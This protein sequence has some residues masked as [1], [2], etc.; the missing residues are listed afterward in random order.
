MIECDLKVFER[1]K[2]VSFSHRQ[3]G[4][5][6]ETLNCA[7]RELAFCCEPIEDEIL[8]PTEHLR[9]V[10]HGFDARTH[11]PSAPGVKKIL[12]DLDIGECPE[13]LEVFPKKIGP[14]RRQIQFEKLGETDRLFL[15]EVLWALENSPA[16]IFQ[17]ILL[18]GR[19]EFGNLHAPNLI[20]GLS[21]LLHDVKAI[22]NIQCLRGFL[23]DDFQVGWGQ[24]ITAP[25]PPRNPADEL[26]RTGLGPLR[27]PGFLQSRLLSTNALFPENS[28]EKSV[29]FLPGLCRCLACGKVVVPLGMKGVGLSSDLDMPPD[30]GRSR[31]IK[32]V[33]RG[34]VRGEHPVSGSYAVKI[35][36]FY[37]PGALVGMSSLGPSPENAKDDSIDPLVGFL[38]ADVPVKIGP[39]AQDGIESLNDP[40]L[41]FRPTFFHNV[42]DLVQKRL[43]VLPRQSDEKLSPILPNVL[44]E[45]VRSLRDVHDAG[46]LFREFQTPFPQESFDGGADFLLEDLFRVPGDN[47]VVG[48]DHRVYPVGRRK[49]G[50]KM[51]SQ[52][53]QCDDCRRWGD[54]ASLRGP[55]QG[56]LER[57]TVDKP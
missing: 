15:R 10:L 29:E 16:A 46:L 6:I 52:P 49:K 57:L 13:S 26:P 56:R 50:R 20:D 19:L 18:S 21:E 40:L 24:R 34:P 7:A 53:G 35:P 5:Q 23:R 42:P 31:V 55:G 54:D 37:P 11:G 47:E 44:A 27:S 51:R 4:F 12:G 45:K 1:L 28:A 14:D 32:A 2:S 25:S 33:L 9:H 22:K 48:I 43:N 30:R 41:R 8:V 3:F 38:R 36:I 17:K 39:S